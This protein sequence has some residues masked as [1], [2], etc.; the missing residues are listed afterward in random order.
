MAISLTGVGAPAW[1]AADPRA[2]LDGLKARADEPGAITRGLA[3][4]DA[5]VAAAPNDYGT[6]W[7][8][9]RA[10]FLASDDDA[11]PKEE[12]SRLGKVGWELG[13]RA[14]AA[15]PRGVE[16][17]FWSALAIG[18]H[19]LGMGIVRALANGIEG[20]FTGELQRAT[21]IDPTYDHGSVFVA[22]GGY[23]M[24]LP[25]PKRDRK[26]AEQALRRAMQINPANLRA[27]VFLARVFAAE[28]RVAEA[29]A[30]LAEVAAA[31][32]GRYDAAEERRAKRSAAK[33]AAKLH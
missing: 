33:L 4:A 23:Y 10:Y 7:R 19:A 1:A 13:Q 28:D 29:R 24:E 22:W 21:D 8:A 27:R 12:R 16:G 17:H 31:P 26:K 14:V 11:R 9:A 3:V 15:N 2:E 5:A 25:W 20:K 6:L 30:L 32:V 18:G